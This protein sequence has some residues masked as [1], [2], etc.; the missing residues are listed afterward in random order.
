[1]AI[2]AVLLISLFVRAQRQP[3]S[4]AIVHANDVHA[5]LAAAAPPPA[6]DAPAR[7]RTTKPPRAAANT[8]GL[9]L[10]PVASDNGI[11]RVD[12]FD[13]KMA[14][15][16]GLMSVNFAPAAQP[17]AAAPEPS[18]GWGAWNQ[19]PAEPLSGPGGLRHIPGL[20][21][22]VSAAAAGSN[23][24]GSP[25]VTGVTPQG[26]MPGG[27]LPGL[28][29]GKA[30]NWHHGHFDGGTL[31]AHQHGNAFHKAHPHSGGR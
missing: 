3:S 25:S 11:K 26:N 27:D 15:E 1:M 8:S 23:S 16:E 21:P 2:A 12:L 30:S 10:I 6:P 28:P 13:K 17:P 5:E 20:T 19:P 18:I 22:T 4:P 14:P 31:Q 24:A 29:S 9:K 7:K